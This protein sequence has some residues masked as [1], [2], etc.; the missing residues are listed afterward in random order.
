MRRRAAR[1]IE[2]SLL[3]AVAPLVAACDDEP[4]DRHCVDDQ[5]A[6]VEDR[7]CEQVEAGPPGTA[8]HGVHWVYVPRRH[9]TGVGGHAGAWVHSTSPSRG[10]SSSAKR[11]GFGSTGH[12]H[13]SSHQAGS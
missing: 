10:H 13:A 7:E 1:H 11:G 9:Y 4:E 6:W 8:R 12:H 5:G 3:L 2:L